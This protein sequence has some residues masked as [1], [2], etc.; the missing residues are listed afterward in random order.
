MK[1]IAGGQ[2]Y[3][4]KSL[5]EVEAT[6]VQIARDIRNQ[7]TLAYYPINAKKDGTFRTVRVEA[8]YPSKRTRL[9]VRTRTGYYAPKAKEP[10]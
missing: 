7:Y 3:F 9:F 10:S 2:A 6:C 8:S 1:A 4:P 5:D